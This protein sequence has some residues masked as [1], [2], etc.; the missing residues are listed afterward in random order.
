ML[1]AKAFVELL[2]IW[3]R[4]LLTGIDNELIYDYLPLALFQALSRLL[5][6]QNSNGFWGQNDSP[7]ETAYALIAIGVLSSLPFVTPVDKEI[8]AALSKGREALETHRA[9]E[10]RTDYLW[11]EKVTYTSP[12]VHEAYIV[13]ALDATTQLDRPSWTSQN[14][15]ILINMAKIAKFLPFYEKL[16]T[17]GSLPSWRIRLSLMEG[18]LF[19]PLLRSVRCEVFPARSKGDGEERYWDNIRFTWS[20]ANSINLTFAS[21]EFIFVGNTGVQL[22]VG[23]YGILVHVG[24][25]FGS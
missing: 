1:M 11:I 5:Q 9:A 18:C 12:V 16:P 21:A 2:R 19:A 24:C 22:T 15:G 23:R 4:N 17:I 6:S 25:G 14:Y 3:D 7:E 10:P 8:N 13:A 20:C